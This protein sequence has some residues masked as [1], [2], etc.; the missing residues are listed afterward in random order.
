[1]FLAIRFGENRKRQRAV[2]SRLVEQALL[3]IHFEAWEPKP[4]HRPLLLTL[5][6]SLSDSRSGFQASVLLPKDAGTDGIDDFE[7]ELLTEF[8]DSSDREFAEQAALLGGSYV[9]YKP[10]RLN[11][12]CALCHTGKPGDFLGIVKI[13]LG[14][15]NE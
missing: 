1:M 3:R 6:D 11:K 12:D 15:A 10:I 4:G 7:K 5:L 8:A 2:S 14:A 13:Q 9:Y